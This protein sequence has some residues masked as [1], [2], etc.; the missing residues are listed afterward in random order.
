MRA[1][2]GPENRRLI[3][4]SRPHHRSCAGAP[5]SLNSRLFRPRSRL[6]GCQRG[7]EPRLPPR[8]EREAEIEARTRWKSASLGTRPPAKS[9]ESGWVLRRG[10][11]LLGPAGGPI[12]CS[13]RRP[14]CWDRERPSRRAK[15]S[16]R[17]RRFDGSLT[18]RTASFMYAIVSG[19]NHGV[20]QGPHGIYPGIPSPF[21]PV[22]L[23]A[24]K[25][26]L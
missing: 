3:A 6:R 20:Q 18:V 7:I 4:P 10:A 26:L 1:E 16:I 19:P 11:A 22:I 8:R 5:R 13:I 25:D 12:P 23:S 9:P 21:L 14:T 24:A 2:A 15:S 17:L